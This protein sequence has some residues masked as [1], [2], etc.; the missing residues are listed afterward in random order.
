[1]VLTR[2]SVYIGWPAPAG[3]G[4]WPSSSESEPEPDSRSVPAAVEPPSPGTSG[5]MVSGSPESV[6]SAS[7]SRTSASSSCG[8]SVSSGRGFGRG[9]KVN[10]APVLSLDSPSQPSTSTVMISPA[11]ISPKRIFSES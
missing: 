7:L 3:G 4:L 1:M 5:V 2:V 11:P 10:F 6:V 8:S 9:L